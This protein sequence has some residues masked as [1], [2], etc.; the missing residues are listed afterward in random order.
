[1]AVNLL[2][3]RRCFVLP[4]ALPG[5]WVWLWRLETYQRSKYILG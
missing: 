2:E 3:M 4:V 1:V 5:N